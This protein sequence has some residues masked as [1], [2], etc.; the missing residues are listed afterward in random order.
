MLITDI[1]GTVSLNNGV[2]MPYLGLG[3]W[4]AQNDEEVINAVKWAVQEGYRH[5]DTA[6][7]YRNEEGVGIGIAGCGIPRED[8]FI[9]SKLWNGDQGYDSTL[10]AFDQSLKK[11][12]VDYLDMYLIHW[13]VAGKYVD[14]WKAMERLYE[15]G[16]I[17]AIGVSNF[18]IHHL[19]DLLSNTEIIPAVNQME[20]HPRLI[21]PELM[22]YC[23]QN[24]IQ[25][26]AW[27]PLM[28]G[29]I[30]HIETFKQLA[31]KYQRS[32]S[33]IVLRWD[34]QKGVITIPKSTNRER[35]RENAQLFGFEI[36]EEDMQLIDELNDH[37]R[38]GP[39][40]DNFDF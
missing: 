16:Q 11:L 28:K 40:P 22:D 4:Q 26:E 9:V 13:P 21:Q 32:I 39:D 38:V 3:V 15:E 1:N 29:E 23:R 10:R 27:S 30:F 2:E 35:I 18:M 31:A 19:Q 37:Y 12:D 6:A 20:F 7:I 25:F 8:L 36:S 5:I 24:G 34:L 14:S 17:K 33:Q